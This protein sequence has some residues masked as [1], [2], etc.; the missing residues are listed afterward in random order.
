VAPKAVL[1]VV[2]NETPVPARRTL[3][4]EGRTVAIP[5]A[6]LGARLALFERGS[7]RLIALSPGKPLAN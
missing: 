3:K 5:V 6:A 4:L 1:V 7:G 2:V